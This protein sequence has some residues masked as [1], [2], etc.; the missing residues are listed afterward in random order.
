[1]ATPDE[2]GEVVP[3]RLHHSASGRQFRLVVDNG[4]VVIAEGGGDGW[5]VYLEDDP[6]NMSSGSLDGLVVAELLG[7]RYGDD[8]PARFDEWANQV[9]AAAPRRTSRSRRPR[10]GAPGSP[11]TTSA[12]G[13]RRVRRR[14]VRLAADRGEPVCA[15]TSPRS[16]RTATSSSTVT[17][18]CRTTFNVYDPRFD[19]AAAA[20]ES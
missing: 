4:R 19:D 5:F 7:Y 6:G 16:R 18:R 10:R 20:A 17:C 9:M 3:P 1:M 13:S 8:Y 2:T 11:S 15:A 14:R 12:V